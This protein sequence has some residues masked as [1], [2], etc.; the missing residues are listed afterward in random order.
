MLIL[1]SGLFRQFQQ[2]IFGFSTKIGLKRSH[3]YY[4]NMSLSVN[5]SKDKVLQ[6]RK[7]FFKRLGL[8]EQT[9]TTQNQAHGDN[10]K[11]VDEGINCGECDAMI[12]DKPHL[13][14]AVSTADCPAIF[15]FEIERKIIA[16]VHSGWRGTEKK[17]LLKVL[18]LLTED[19]KSNPKKIVAYI[20]PSISQKNYGVGEE[21]A[22]LFE[23]KYSIKKKSKYLLDL[24]RMNRDILL[25]FGLSKHNIQ[26]SSLCSFEMQ[27]FLHSYRRDGEL[28]GRAFGVIAMKNIL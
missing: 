20:S 9:V 17:I 19:Y 10:V 26:V 15:L 3:P 16:A 13:G 28:S 18:T 11:F 14:L 23:E 8:D 22:A 4:F 5:D 7:F 25:N 1:R 2:I 12:T 27:D 21:V 6:N 24:K